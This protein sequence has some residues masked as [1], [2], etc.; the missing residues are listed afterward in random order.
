[1]PPWKLLIKTGPQDGDIRANLSHWN[2]AKGKLQTESRV[3]STSPL[4][5][6]ARKRKGDKMQI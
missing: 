5:A 2:E 1:M 4:Y 3:G 6:E